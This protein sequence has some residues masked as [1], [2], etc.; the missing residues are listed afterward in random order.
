MSVLG[1]PGWSRP[2]FERLE[3]ALDTLCELVRI[4]HLDSYDG[5]IIIVE[6][7]EG[8]I[9]L[10]TR[11]SNRKGDYCTISTY[12]MEL[13]ENRRFIHRNI[14]QDGIT[15]FI[16]VTLGGFEASELFRLM[17]EYDH[18]LLV[19]CFELILDRRFDTAI[20]EASLVLE[21]RLK[22]V[23]NSTSWGIDLVNEAFG[24]KGKLSQRFADDGKRQAMRDLMAGVMGVIRNDFAH[25][26][27]SSSWSQ[28]IAVVGFIN[29]LLKQLNEIANQP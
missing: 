24:S 21:T 14:N 11:T 15:Q 12:R 5:K 23:I 18:D 2:R 19:K 28:T 7:I 1:Y 25:N 6:E 10:G 3:E 17:R 27:R 26:F 29:M 20:R 8:K 9:L 22:Q 16:W 13:L 4:I